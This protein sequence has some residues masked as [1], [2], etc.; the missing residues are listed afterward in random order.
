VEPLYFYRK[1]ARQAG[2]GMMI[3]PPLVVAGMVAVPLFM[4][5]AVFAWCSGLFGGLVALVF[6]VF[7]F[8]RVIYGGEWG[9]LVDR[10]YITW[11][12]PKRLGSLESRELPSWL[13]WL[14]GKQKPPPGPVA[15]P[16]QDRQLSV[17]EV[18]KFMVEIKPGM[19][20][21]EDG[22][23]AF[24]IETARDTFE[25]HVDCFA[26]IDRLARALLIANP[27]IQ[28]EFRRKGEVQPWDPDHPP[29]SPAAVF[30]RLFGSLK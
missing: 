21:R 23:W 3:G 8:R 30:G 9:C 15:N 7:G 20:D 11:V 24:F 18:T 27:N 6:F 19:S 17:H 22:N 5:T 28:L 13:H 1:G 2:I 25:I 12:Y 16:Y 10:H 26:R 4:G 14:Y 29:S